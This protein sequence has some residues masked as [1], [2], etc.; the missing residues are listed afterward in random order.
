MCVYSMIVDHFAD[1]WLPGGPPRPWPPEVPPPTPPTPAEV[2]DFRR[3]LEK[4]RLYDR[5]HAQP[6]CGTD[7]KRRRLRELAAALG[8]D[9]AF[10]DDDKE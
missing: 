5:R 9:I 7:D 6:D 4:A 1:K 10:P 3:L 2:E 8:V